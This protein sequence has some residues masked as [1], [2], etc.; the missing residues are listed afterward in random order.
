M[1][2]EIRELRDGSN[3]AVFEVPEAELNAIVKEADAL[4]FA[5]SGGA[6]VDLTVDRVDDLLSVRG[7]I[8]AMAGFECARCLTENERPIAMKLRWTLVPRTELSGGLS[9]DEE[10]GLTT[11]DL[12]V[13][14]YEGEEIDLGDLVREA[15]LLELDPAPRC[16]VDSCVFTTYTTASAEP[17]DAPVDPRWAPLAALRGKVRGSD[18]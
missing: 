12:E 17:A 9:N 3:P 4:Y 13:S 6:K 14:F 5:R 10:V 7:T 11:D 16:G 2:I 1:K 15:L 8:D 18:S